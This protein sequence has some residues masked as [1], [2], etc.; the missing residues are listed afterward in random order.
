MLGNA[1]GDTHGQWDFGLEGLFDTGSCYGGSARIVNRV[2]HNT[3]KQKHGFSGQ[4]TLTGQ[5]VPS[6]LRQSP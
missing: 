2:K 3:Q 1:L 5:I 4:A 6:P